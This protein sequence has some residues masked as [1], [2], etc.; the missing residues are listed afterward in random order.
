MTYC[1]HTFNPSSHELN[2]RPSTSSPQKCD[3]CDGYLL[4]CGNCSAPNR[5]AAI[6]CTTCSRK[7]ETNGAIDD[8]SLVKG[9]SSRVNDSSEYRLDKVLRCSVDEKPLLWISGDEGV[10]IF[11][12]NPNA[13]TYQI[14]LSYIPD[15]I[16]KQGHGQSLVT[17]NIL[18]N[19]T[20]WAQRPIVSTQGLFI[21]TNYALHYFPSHGYEKKYEHQIWK[22][23][24]GESI[25]SI[26]IEQTKNPSIL[27]KDSDNKLVILEGNTQSGAWGVGNKRYETEIEA[28][29]GAAYLITTKSFVHDY[30][31]YDGLSLIRYSTETKEI[32][33]SF[34][35]KS[36]EKIPSSFNEK[37]K[38]G[39]FPPFILE[40]KQSILKSVLP[41]TT[42]LDNKVRVGVLPDGNTSPRMI[43]D[44]HP[45]IWIK[46]YPGKDGFALGLPETVKGYAGDQE[47][48]RINK[49]KTTSFPAIL[50][51]NW[52]ATLVL[53]DNNP[54]DGTKAT[55]AIIFVPASLIK[56]NYI[57]EERKM[58]TGKI[59]NNGT[60]VPGLPPIYS[61]GDIFIA[62]ENRRETTIYQIQI[63][64]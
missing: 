2:T 38:R 54:R 33:S 20:E 5:L 57:A 61:N 47:K 24:E 60:P 21:P 46:A 15:F 53:T 13:S 18:P 7:I 42:P 9:V 22:P 4:T 19:F 31:I 55:P 1:P 10:F 29:N 63:S 34:T 6:Y 44:E 26:A 58:M 62:L 28:G 37:I 8:S 50:T 45:H 23:N 30:W 36:G 16:F 51:K 27:I 35:I 41:I 17:G 40:D 59:E 14:S 39:Y 64:G 52:L 43:N 11:T 25:L 12:H 49:A 3:E 48:W 32:V 56:G